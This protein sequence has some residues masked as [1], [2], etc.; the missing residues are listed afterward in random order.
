MKLL[1]P[2]LVLI[3]LPLFA[4]VVVSAD[5]PQLAAWAPCPWGSAIATRASRT[6]SAPSIGFAAMGMR[7]AFT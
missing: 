5:T 6:R 1:A 2:V 7:W 3:A 4:P